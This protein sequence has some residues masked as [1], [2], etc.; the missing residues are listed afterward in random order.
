MSTKLQSVKAPHRGRA[1]GLAAILALG[2][3]RASMASTAYGS[4]NNFDCVNDTGVE[5]HGFEIELDYGRTTD[6]TYTYDYNHYGKPTITEDLTDPAHPKVFV[7]YAGTRDALGHWSAYTAIPSGPIAPTQGHQFTNPAI[8]FGGEHFGVGFNG[9]PVAVKYNWLIDDGSGK[10]IHGP[11]VYIST[12]SFAYNPPVGGAPA[13]VVAVVVPPP[14]PAPPP[15]QFGA[16]QWVKEIKTTSHNPKKVHLNDLVG[17]DPGKPQPWANGEKPEVEMEWRVLQTEFAAANGGKNG[18][19]AGAPEDLPGGNEMVTRRYEFY[20][21]IGPLDAETGEAVGDTVGPDGIHG[22]G[23]ITYADHFDINTGEWVTVT[24]DM[25]KVKVVGDFFGAQMAGFDVAPNLGLIDNVQDGSV[26]TVYPRRTVVIGGPRAFTAS[27]KTGSLPAGML[28]DSVTGIL[29]GTPMSSGTFNFTVEAKDTGGT[30]VSHAYTMK[31][32]GGVIPPT[33]YLITTTA[34]PIAG[35]TTTGGGTYN[36]GAA[37]TVNATANNGYY[38]VNWKAAGIAVSTAPTYKFTATTNVDLVANFSAYIAITTA[39]SPQ[40]GGTTTGGGATFKPGT[41]VTIK[42]T[43]NPGYFFMNWRDGATVVS[44]NATFTFSATV[45]RT[46]TANFGTFYTI[47]TAGWPA[48]GG[49]TSGGGTAFKTG[50][51]VALKATPASNY[52]FANWTEGAN[53]VSTS[54]TYAFPAAANR[55]LV[56][57]FL[58]YLSVVVVASPSGFGTVSGGGTKFKYGDKVTVT[59]TP[60]TGYKF[61]GWLDGSTIVS[62]TNA[63]TFTASSYRYLVANFAKK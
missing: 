25:S 9:N 12:P 41:S 15:L 10:L 33:T 13:Q 27:V 14:P 47:T 51:T 31:V 55:D 50:T 22:I 52:Y 61:L 49:S 46:L 21:Y 60:K 11:A 38:F 63:Y 2:L 24:V 30:T 28:L 59:A 45:N 8:N 20:K 23:T 39:Q 1:L 26:N 44:T 34:A 56:A 16:A 7:R 43:A 58:P 3:S 48:I 42:A 29:S 6:I 40:A 5:T 36:K 54:P 53:S 62:A 57:N 4:I 19:L 32:A 18:A 37:V 35:G 17:D